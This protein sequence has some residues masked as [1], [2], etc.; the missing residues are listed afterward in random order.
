MVA[1]SSTSTA[2]GMMKTGWSKLSNLLDYECNSSRGQ[3]Y[4]KFCDE[5]EKTKKVDVHVEEK[6]GR[7][8]TVA[9]DV[10]EDTEQVIE[11]KVPAGVKA[12]ESVDFIAPDGSQLRVAVPP[13]FSPGD[14]MFLP[15]P[16]RANSK[17]FVSWCKKKL[18][19]DSFSK[20]KSVP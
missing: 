17:G 12:G 3:D 15:V 11:I 9:I 10:G 4:S 6:N 7:T 18:E 1:T 2:S 5:Q 14:R 16:K 20:S 8:Q 19:I 13:G